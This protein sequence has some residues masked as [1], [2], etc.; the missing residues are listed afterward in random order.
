M[1][2]HHVVVETLAGLAD[3]LFRP[4]RPE[5]HAGSVEPHEERFVRFRL[6]VDEFPRRGDKFLIRRFHA[7]AGQGARVL[8]LAVGKGV[9]YAA[10]PELLLEPGHLRVV[11]V[12][13]LLLGVEVIQVAQELVETVIGR[14]MFIPVSQVI[15]AELTGGIT[16][17]LEHLG[18]SDI[19]ILD[20]QI[21]TGQAHFGQACAKPGLARDKGRAPRRAAL[22]AVV[23]GK[24]HALFG[25]AVDI[26]RAI[27][28]DPVAV[29]ADI[30]NADIVA[31]DDQNIGLICRRTGE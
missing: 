20:P 5:V 28:H 27:A 6:P 9:D 11:L 1:G 2:H 29:G 25:N 17:G 26:R 21:G 18:D 10:W 14:Q 24:A 23:V 15:F 22:V 7:L 16:P 31:P 8:D 30:G 3:V 4:V 19:P 13:G 12:L